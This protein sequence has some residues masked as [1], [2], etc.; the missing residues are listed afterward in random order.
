MGGA[1]EPSLP[2]LFVLQEHADP[3]L[4]C[5]F[6]PSEV[7]QRDESN[8]F[9][10]GDTGGLVVLWNL[11]TRRKIVSFSALTEAH[12][13]LRESTRRGRNGGTSAAGELVPENEVPMEQAATPAFG[14]Y[15]QS[16]LSVG[17]IPTSLSS[18]QRATRVESRGDI[19]DA[20]VRG[21]C[22]E[23][24]SSAVCP[25]TGD[26][27]ARRASDWA[28][29]GR[30]RFRLS[31]RAAA[32]SVSSRQALPLSAGD[33]LDSSPP[34][35]G[36]TPSSTICFYTHCRDQRVYIWCLQR[37]CVSVPDASSHTVVPQLIVALTAPQ[38]GFCPVESIS[39]VAGPFT[40]T[41]LAVPHEVGGEVTVWELAWQQ[42]NSADLTS[43]TTSKEKGPSNEPQWLS[44]SVNVDEDEGK[45]ANTSEMNPMDAL[46]A[47]AAEEERQQAKMRQT[48]SGVSKEIEAGIFSHSADVLKP[49]A[50]RGERASILCYVDPAAT[51]A[52]SNFSARRLCSFSACPT[53]KGGTIMRLTMC[54]DAQHLSVAFESGHVVLA[55]YRDADGTRT[56]SRP[57]E[58]HHPRET[59]PNVQ[60]RNITRAFAESALVCWWSGRRMLACSSE[61]G[62]HCYD[63]LETAGALLEAKLVWSVTLRKGIGSVFLQRNLIVAG[64]WDSTLR[65]YDARDGRLVS[66]L[67]YQKETVNEVRMAPP[68]IARVAAFGFDMRQPRLYASSPSTLSTAITPRIASSSSAI[69][70]KSLS[71]FSE[72]PVHDGSV[73]DVAVPKISL[74]ANNAEEQLVYLFASASKDRTVALWRVDLWRVLEETTCKAI[75]A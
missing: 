28:Q 63:M 13:Q 9:L 37:Q 7:Y 70:E 26:C 50:S 14:P 39:K 47:R 15:I 3:V 40:R 51:T 6:Y 72:S 43:G 33:V 54:Q 31:R 18:P 52:S 24:S 44:G 22:S 25:A 75:T 69:A 55:R 49:V 32:H 36:F 12:R 68:S 16:I 58:A 66:I 23:V 46:I 64:C 67:S 74:E 38:H 61:G 30:Q 29:P 21:I 48:F 65:L 4:C 57:G 35:L 5:K 1:G 8:W 45:E 60:V 34:G 2:P 62:M 42:P 20:S 10:S 73:S 17:F 27:A 53:F 19:A 59:L 41:F 11:A 56:V 71:Q